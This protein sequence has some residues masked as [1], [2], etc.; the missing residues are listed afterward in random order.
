MQCMGRVYSV[1]THGYSWLMVQL[2]LVC[3]CCFSFPATI[4]VMS[5]WPSVPSPRGA[6]GQV[7]EPQMVLKRRGPA[8]CKLDAFYKHLMSFSKLFSFIYIPASCT[9]VGGE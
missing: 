1:V 6:R 3:T 5:V 8:P 9:V 4:R 2:M 7:C